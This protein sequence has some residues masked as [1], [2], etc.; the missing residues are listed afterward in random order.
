MDRPRILLANHDGRYSDRLS[1]AL[2]ES[3]AS[4]LDIHADIHAASLADA[5]AGFVGGAYDVL[6]CGQESEAEA[7][8][9]VEVRRRGGRLPIIALI[10][11]NDG[12]LARRALDGGANFVVP[13]VQDPRSTAERL[14]P[15]LRLCVE[16]ARTNALCARSEGNVK[17]LSELIRETRRLVDDAR[18]A[19]A[20][21]LRD[22]VPLLVVEDDPFMADLLFRAL[23][24][25]RF[26]IPQLVR[27][28]EQ[29]V[30]ALAG[31]GPFTALAPE[32]ILLD[33]RMPG[34]SGFDVLRRMKEGSDGIRAVPA[35]V[36]SDSTDPEDERRARELGA[37]GYFRKPMSL[38]GM[39]RLISDVR[40]IWRTLRRS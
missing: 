2:K 13:K 7:R 40:A 39:R 30:E 1:A 34:L 10:P 35:I 21:D 5:L 12:A 32:L 15:V 11:P 37:I 9:V 16:T 4:S 23:R 17:A 29:A 27:S 38:E 22:L 33:L 26:G 19:T 28:G 14:E 25:A 24:S 3:K 20:P 6:V 36:C 31:L 18:A 8:W